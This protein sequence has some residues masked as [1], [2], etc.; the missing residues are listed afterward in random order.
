M[1][2]QTALE[3]KHIRIQ[4]LDLLK[5]IESLEESRAENKKREAMPISKPVVFRERATSVQK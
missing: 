4:L 5:R 1:S 3:M 2:F